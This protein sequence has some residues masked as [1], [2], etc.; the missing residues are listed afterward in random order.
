MC[1]VSCRAALTEILTT[2]TKELLV[3]IKEAGDKGEHKRLHALM[4]STLTF[5]TVN[6]LCAVPIAVLEN[7]DVSIGCFDHWRDIANF[8]L[9][10]G[11]MSSYRCL[12]GATCKFRSQE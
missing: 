7:V 11:H 3:L 6:E 8:G 4:D 5:I 9:K 12:I 1:R 2:V 10:N